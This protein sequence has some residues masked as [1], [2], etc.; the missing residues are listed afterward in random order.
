MTY[1]AN[2]QSFEWTPRSNFKDTPRTMH[3][4]VSIFVG[5]SNA[6]ETYMAPSTETPWAHRGITKE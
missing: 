2:Y 3:G 5:E 1:A 6:Q 4:L